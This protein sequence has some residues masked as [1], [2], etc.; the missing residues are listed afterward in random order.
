MSIPSSPE[1]LLQK[2]HGS[3]TCV[4][5][6]HVTEGN[7]PNLPSIDLI[8]ILPK[9]KCRQVENAFNNSAVASDKNGAES[10][11][12]PKDS[13]CRITHSCLHLTCQLIEVDTSNSCCPLLPVFDTATNIS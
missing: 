2:Q 11:D 12:G 9:S 13:C 7:V 1:Q 6:A 10:A 3:D 8:A 4:Y 5:S